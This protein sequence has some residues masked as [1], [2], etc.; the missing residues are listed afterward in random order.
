MYL[1][2]KSLIVMICLFV[3]SFKVAS[4]GVF[5]QSAI[6]RA[7]LLSSA[8]TSVEIQKTISSKNSVEDKEPVHSM[9]LMSHVLAALS[10][11][12]IVMPLISERQMKYSTASDPYHADNIP[13]SVYKPP[14]N[15]A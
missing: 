10:E 12:T 11:S 15:N 4:G 6:E 7:H 1:S 5:I 9:Y 2:K 13:D 8:Y 14:K 3:I